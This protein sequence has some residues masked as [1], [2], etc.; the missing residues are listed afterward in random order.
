VPG[1]I[2]GVTFEVKG[3]ARLRATLKNVEEGLEDLKAVHAEVADIVVDR[4]QTTVP[5]LTGQLAGTIRGSGTR[6]MAVV[7]AGYAKVPYAGVQEF[8][9]P[10]RNIPPN[11]Y[12]RP[13]AKE[14]EPTWLRTYNDEIEELLSKVKGI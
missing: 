1:K 5:R 13:A 12:L 2:K 11:P 4:A 14:T 7:R 9:W 6:T 3:G 10:R 8:G